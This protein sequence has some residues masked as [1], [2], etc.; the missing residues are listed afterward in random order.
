M[1][2]CPQ[3]TIKILILQ[4]TSLVSDNIFRCPVLFLSPSESK[5]CMSQLKLACLP[6]QA[7]CFTAQAMMICFVPCRLDQAGTPQPRATRESLRELDR[8]L[9]KHRQRGRPARGD[10]LGGKSR[11]VP[12]LAAIPGPRIRERLHH[13]YRERGSRGAR[14]PLSQQIL[15]CLRS[16]RSANIFAGDQGSFHGNWGL[17]LC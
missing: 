1:P 16:L 11:C 2:C 13:G 5:A 8:R 12:R 9:W 10:D 14:G 3:P 7:G 4:P 17:Q 6:A 15:G